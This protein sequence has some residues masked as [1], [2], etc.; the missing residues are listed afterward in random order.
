MATVWRTGNKHY[1]ATLPRD[2]QTLDH[3][4]RV[5]LQRA[6]HAAMSSRH[7]HNRQSFNVLLR[8]F[9]GGMRWYRTLTALLS[10]SVNSVDTFTSLIFSLYLSFSGHGFPITRRLILGFFLMTVESLR[11]K[12]TKKPRHPHE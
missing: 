8:F 4:S 1:V 9:G 3:N 6:L 10:T 11:R 12:T 5:R 7:R 2:P